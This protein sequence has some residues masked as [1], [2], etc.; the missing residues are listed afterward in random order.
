M[1]GLDGMDGPFCDE[2]EDPEELEELE[3]TVK[4]TALNL[5]DLFCTRTGGH[6]KQMK[7]NLIDA[8]E[9]CKCRGPA[10]A[11][12]VHQPHPLP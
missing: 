1:A 4:E 10:D 8:A 7:L 11:H 5:K 2:A 12:P 9:A 3:A 6:T